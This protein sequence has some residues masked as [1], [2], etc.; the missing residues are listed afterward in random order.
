LGMI[1]SL[2]IAY[3]FFV[4]LW[5]IASVVTNKRAARLSPHRLSTRL[6]IDD[7]IPF[8]PGFAAAY[9]SGFVLGNM[10]YVV[11]NSSASFPRV[12]LGYLVLFLVG[13]MFYVLCPCRVDRREEIMVTDVSTHLLSMFQQASK[14]FNS[15]PSMHVAYCLF[16]AVAV[17]RHDYT[18]LGAVLLLW[19]LLVTVSTLLTKQHHVLDVMVGASVALATLWVTQP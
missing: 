6:R 14:P 15:F 5:A 11:L 12:F 16:S 8:V 9:F 2:R 4:I 3:P 1:R 18:A 17:L 10:G 13:I 7:A 19:A